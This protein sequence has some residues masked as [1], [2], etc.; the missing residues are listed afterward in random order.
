MSNL[1]L[2]NTNFENLKKLLAKK[3]SAT[4]GYNTVVHRTYG[5]AT[6]QFTIRFHS[7]AIAFIDNSGIVF[8]NAGWGTPTTRNRLSIIADDNNVPVHF[9]QQNFKQTVWA[10]K[11]MWNQ[12]SGGTVLNMVTDEFRSVL[13]DRATDTLIHNNETVFEF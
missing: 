13:W 12:T 7:N 3:S 4:V 8:T 9:G 6:D 10:R 11:R 5:E 2:K 1:K